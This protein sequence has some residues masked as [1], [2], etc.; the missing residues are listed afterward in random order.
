MFR[1]T[2]R[3]EALAQ[4]VD[5]L[6]EIAS[7]AWLTANVNNVTYTSVTRGSN[8]AATSATVVWPDGTGGTYTATTVSTAFPGA[9]DAFTVT[10]ADQQ[11][12]P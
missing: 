6:G 3:T 7:D 9:V 8:G 11:Q 10:Y 4:D 2:T 12:R 5:P 1:R